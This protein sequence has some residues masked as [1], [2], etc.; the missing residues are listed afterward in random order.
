MGNFFKNEEVYDDDGG[1]QAYQEVEDD[2]VEVADEVEDVQEDVPVE[3]T[4]A[5]T[6]R[7]GKNNGGSDYVFYG[8]F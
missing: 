3:P 5:K 4:V 8:D 7:R 6:D 1:F 2:S